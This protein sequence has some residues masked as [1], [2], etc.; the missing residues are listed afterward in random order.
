MDL[1]SLID[2]KP[3]PNVAPFRPGDTVRVHA[4]VV[5]GDRERLQAFEGV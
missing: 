1:R 4:R 2:V 5:E 3:N